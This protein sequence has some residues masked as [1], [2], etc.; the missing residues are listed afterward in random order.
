MPLARINGFQM[1]YEVV[2]DGPTIL[3]IHGGMGGARSLVRAPWDAGAALPGHQFIFYDR[4]GV[5]RSEA[6]NAG[7]DLTT[8]GGDALCLLDYLGV[9]RATVLGTSAGGPIALQLAIQAPDRVQALILANTSACIW[10]SESDDAYLVQRLLHV[11]DT[12]GPEAAF[13]RRPPHARHSLEP[14]WRWPEADAHGWL[15]RSRQ[16][17]EDL[18]RQAAGLPWEEQIQRHVAEL[19][20]C[21]A[22]IGAD[23][24]LDL[25]QIRCPVLLIHG[26]ADTVIPFSASEQLLRAL[27][28]SELVA[29]RG[30]GHMILGRPEAWQA[31]STFLRHVTN[32]GRWP[33]SPLSLDDPSHAVE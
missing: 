19:L 29:I 7:Y 8:F 20:T 21:R 13:E 3:Y 6:P 5:A 14:I 1:Y 17:E 25:G 27:P 15:D 26:E 16:E 12:D 33:R 32:D 11:L 24:S 2:G 31:I 30:A 23:Q 22:Y 9:E 10:P 4:R 28:H 18:A